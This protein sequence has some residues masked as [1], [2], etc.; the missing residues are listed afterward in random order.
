MDAI[1]YPGRSNDWGGL[2][3]GP[4]SL[5]SLPSPSPPLSL[6]P[7]P[8]PS[9]PLPSPPLPSLLPPPPPSPPLPF[10]PP[11]PFLVGVCPM[12]ASV[13]GSMSP[14]Q[15]CTPMRS[16]TAACVQG[17]RA[18]GGVPCDRLQ[19]PLI[20]APKGQRYARVHPHCITL[21][22]R[23]PTSHCPKPHFTTAHDTALPRGRCIYS[24]PASPPA[25]LP[26]PFHAPQ[27]LCS[28]P[29]N[30]SLRL[31]PLS[32]Q[33][34]RRRCWG[35]RNVYNVYS[36]LCAFSACVPLS[37]APPPSEARR[38]ARGPAMYT[39]NVYNVCCTF[40][41]CAPSPRRRSGGAAGGGGGICV[42][43]RERARLPGARGQP[44]PGPPLSDPL[45]PS[46]TWTLPQAAFL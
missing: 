46:S 36:V 16:L 32:R 24:C 12:A 34:W 38:A 29:C 40:S 4:G 30:V 9:P 44:P 21:H 27:T 19:V 45:R 17:P 25:N 23:H 11:P 1:V 31:H 6:P 28:G 3:S 41:S 15:Y 14:V 13:P 43:A 39:H 42:R 37:L 7:L 26:L 2:Q 35:P 18:D 5:P 8:S 33:A 22:P 20:H 10:P